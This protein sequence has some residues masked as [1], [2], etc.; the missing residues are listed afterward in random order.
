MKQIAVVRKLGQAIDL[1]EA[2]IK[3]IQGKCKHERVL[4]TEKPDV[5]CGWGIF[6]KCL[7]CGKMVYVATVTNWDRNPKPIRKIVR[8]KP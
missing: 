2:R 7:E 1:A 8:R 5:Y 3:A 6:D 4:H